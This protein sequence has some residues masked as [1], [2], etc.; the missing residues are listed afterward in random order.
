MTLIILVVVQITDNTVL[1]GDR[2]FMLNMS[3]PGV[4]TAGQTPSEV[5]VIGDSAVAMVTIM[6]NENDG[7]HCIN[8]PRHEKI[9]FLHMQKQRC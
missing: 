3:V 1:N 7:E 2:Q 9:C 4:P 8:E 6:D 5:A